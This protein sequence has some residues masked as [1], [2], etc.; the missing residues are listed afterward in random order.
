MKT[1]EIYCACISNSIN[2]P[3]A[4]AAILKYG[5]AKKEISGSF[6]N[7]DINRLNLVAIISSIGTLKESCDIIIYIDSDY[8][9]DA[10]N[11][12]AIITWK[13]NDWK[14][15]NNNL[16][17]NEDI[18]RMLLIQT[19]VK[20]HNIRFR[21]V[22]IKDNIFLYAKNNAKIELDKYLQNDIYINS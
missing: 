21:K 18:W 16:I 8:V 6:P 15:N 2:S 9:F 3:G 12:K 13:N 1:V 7:T 4:W 10:I 20:K 14:D 11:S 19:K 17:L 5:N 22:N